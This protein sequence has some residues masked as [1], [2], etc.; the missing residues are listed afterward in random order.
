M[1]QIE[2][3]HARQILD[4]RGNPTVECEVALRSGASGRA[5]VPSARPP[6]SSR[7]WSCATAATAW[8]GKGV[9]RAVANVNGEIAQAVDGA[10]AFDQAAL[11]RALIDLDG[12]PNKSRLGANAILAVSLAAAHAAAAEERQPLWRY[13]GGRA[14]TCCPCRDERPQRRGPRRQ[15]GGLPGVHGG[16]VGRRDRSRTACGSGP[17]S[18]ITSNGPC[19]SAAWA[20]R[21]ATRAGS[22]PTSSPTRRLSSPRR[23]HRGRRLPARRGRDD[24]AGPGDERGPPRRRL[25]ARARGRTLSSAEMADYWAD[26]TGRYPIVSI[27]DGMDE[28]DWE[29]WRR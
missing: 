25:C 1:S 3:V 12:T 29:G 20:P 22:L 24:R 16:P 23:R 2:S 11:D 15:Q 21:W 4:S 18:S 10:D 28:E 26:L 14:P 7:P 19:T 9:A 13:L 8:L 17:R 6:V 27:E 5:A